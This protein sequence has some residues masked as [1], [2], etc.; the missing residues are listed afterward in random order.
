VIEGLDM[1]CV[2]LEGMG[3]NS[4][5]WMAR[6]ESRMAFFYRLKVCVAWGKLC[7]LNASMIGVVVVV[8]MPGIL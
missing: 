2:L 4:F 5:G 7:W 6:F 3:K 8:M 1:W